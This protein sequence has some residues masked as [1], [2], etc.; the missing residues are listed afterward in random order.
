MDH[1]KSTLDFF[2]LVTMC[3]ED[4]QVM[5]CMFPVFEGEGDLHTSHTIEQG[6]AVLEELLALLLCG[7]P[8]T[9][10]QEVFALGL[11]G[12]RSQKPPRC[13]HGELVEL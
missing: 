12:P 1:L 13:L 10:C 7:E 5:D 3:A 9:A 2:H 8:I 6:R 11:E 4:V